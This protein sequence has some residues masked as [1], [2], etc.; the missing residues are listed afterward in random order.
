MKL[1][2][3]LLI[4]SKSCQTSNK[5]P[6]FSYLLTQISSDMFNISSLFILLIFIT[7]Y[8]Y[9]YTSST[10][11]TTWI[12]FLVAE[13]T[14]VYLYHIS[15]NIHLLV[16]LFCICCV[17]S[18]FKTIWNQVYVFEMLEKHMSNFI[19]CVTINA[20]QIFPFFRDKWDAS[21]HIYYYVIRMRVLY[22]KMYYISF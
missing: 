13:Q 3:R 4:N 16:E 7:I 12:N 10:T 8:K 17:K 15:G 20:F 6:V 9:H 19:I 5:F 2:V 14:Y 22:M 11:N 1:R 21:L 18:E